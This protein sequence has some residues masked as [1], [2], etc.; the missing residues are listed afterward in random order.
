MNNTAI[1]RHL[2]IYR[3]VLRILYRGQYRDRFS[4]AC[5]QLR[6]TDR[7]VLE[8]CFADVVVADYCRR[9]A[10]AWIGIDQ[11]DAFVAYARRH[12]FDARQADLLLPAKLPRC[13]VCVMMGSLY[14]FKGELEN[15]FFRI[16]ACSSRLVL[17]EPVTNWAHA[18]GLRRLLAACFTCAEPHADLFRFTEP[19]L[20]Q[21]LT[22]L[23]C[24]VG[25]EY[26]VVHTARD[27][28]VEVTW[29]K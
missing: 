25:F 1:Y 11:S 27:M 5:Q 16:K 12:R 2:W 28:L 22:A 23:Q 19:S 10:M 18:K 17:S 29:L 4:R 20:V 8:L 13:D 6:E 26:R 21:T 7:T 15:L 24:D 9:H 3:M 14:Q